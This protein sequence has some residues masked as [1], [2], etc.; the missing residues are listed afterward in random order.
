[1]LQ[2]QGL[3]LPALVKPEGTMHNPM[4]CIGGCPARNRQLFA[5]GLVSVT[6]TAF[7]S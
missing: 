3:P 1:M 7:A 4:G 5:S 6:M 2:Q